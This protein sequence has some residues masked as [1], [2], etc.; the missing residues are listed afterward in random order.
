MSIGQEYLNIPG[1]M[2]VHRPELVTTTF[3]GQVELKDSL[4]LSL[5]RE[6]KTFP[7]SKLISFQ[8]EYFCRYLWLP[9]LPLAGSY[10]P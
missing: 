9:F 10:I 1:G 7:E 2:Y 3:V 6:L 8:E 5:V 4:A